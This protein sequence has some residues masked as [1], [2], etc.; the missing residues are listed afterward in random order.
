MIARALT[1]LACLAALQLGCQPQTGGSAPA[2][3]AGSGS[4]APAGTEGA[5]V[6]ARIGDDEITEAALDAWIKDEL[7]E[8]ESAGGSPA[9]VYELRRRM[10]DQLLMERV[11]GAEAARRGLSEDQLIDAEVAAM[12][13]ITEEEVAAFYQERIDQMGGQSLEQIAPRIRDYL[14]HVRSQDAANALFD[15]AGVAVLLEQP[16]VEVAADGPAKGPDDARVTIVE[17]SDFQCPFCSRA[18]PT[19][20]AVL[21][22]YPKDVRF[23]YRHMPLDPIHPRARPA[24]EASACADAQGQFWPYHDLLFAN[25][26]TLSDADLERFAGQL[27]L[28]VDA[29]KQCV[30]ERRFE[31]KVEGDVAAGR[32]VGVTGT[33]AFIVNGLMLSGAVPVEEFV[34]VIEAEL[35]RPETAET[36]ESL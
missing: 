4:A 26:K 12:G 10:L 23:V 24:A 5:R 3:G 19:I 28:D 27:N 14:K 30:A 8:R 33:P 31:A 9:K 16:R 2:P 6:V 11:L 32:A 17:F 13:E 22:R 35:K 34:E 25:S 29:W 15:A 20:D 7:Y 18:L 36:P 1:L 21:A